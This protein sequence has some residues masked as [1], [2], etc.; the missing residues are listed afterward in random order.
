MP[1][2]IALHKILLRWFALTSLSLFISFSNF[3][4]V[5]LKVKVLD[6]NDELVP[7]VIVIGSKEQYKVAT[8]TATLD[9]GATKTKLPDIIDHL[10]FVKSG[11]QTV[12]MEY[13][14]KENELQVILE[15]VGS[16]TSTTKSSAMPQGEETIA[17]GSEKNVSIRVVLENGKTIPDLTLEGQ[18]QEFTTSKNGNVSIPASILPYINIKGYKILRTKRPSGELIIVVTEDTSKQ[19]LDK[20]FESVVKQVRTEQKQLEETNAI[21][22]L[23]INSILKRL[24]TEKTLT[25]Q[26]KKKLRGHLK[27]LTDEINQGD[28]KHE[29]NKTKRDQLLEKLNVLLLEKDSINKLNQMKIQQLE[30]EKEMEREASTKRILIISLIALLLSAIILVLMFLMRKVR[31]QR[32]TLQVQN[33]E[34]LAQKERIQTVYKELNDNIISAKVIQNAILPGKGLMKQVLPQLSVFYQP[35]NIVSGDF[36]WFYRK[37]N[38]TMLAAVDCTGHGVAGAFMSFLGYEILNEIARENREIE[39]GQVLSQL[40]AKLIG[41]L[42]IYGATGVNSGMDISLCV[43]DFTKSSLEFAGANNPL[44]LLRNGKTELEQFSADRQGIGGRQKTANFQFNTHTIPFAQGD[45]FLLFSDGYADQIG[46]DEGNQKFMYHRFRKLFTEMA[47]LSPENREH[48]LEKQFKDWKGNQEQLDD[49]LVI[50][51]TV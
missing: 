18:N 43:V 40:N 7:N 16:S 37:G 44:Y 32:G 20:S 33:T 51:F 12:S 1:T 50:A 10:K 2:I 5:A 36:Y 3:A 49:V 31:K 45:T 14:E 29:E 28:K 23:E 19:D 26:E 24:E 42:N 38:K 13:F 46:G 27:R 48:L 25:P 35:K 8:G 11:W 30:T 21:I 41:A 34:I 6:G 9:F 15:E 17:N 39:A 4:Q 22:V 47:P